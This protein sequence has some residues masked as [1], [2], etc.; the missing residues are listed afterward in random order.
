MHSWHYI[1][2]SINGVWLH[3]RQ[4]LS[5]TGTLFPYTVVYTAQ[6]TVLS[7]CTE[8]TGS[9]E[10][11]LNMFLTHCTIILSVTSCTITDYDYYKSKNAISQHTY[12]HCERQQT[13][14]VTVLRKTYHVQARSTVFRQCRLHHTN[15]C[16]TCQWHS[17]TS[18]QQSNYHNLHKTSE[19]TGVPTI[20]HYI[21]SGRLIITS[22]NNCSRTRT[23]CCYMKQITI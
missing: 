8:Q 2:A 3:C 14:G 17:A 19:Y 22:N 4:P 10:T 12:L 11:K 7:G 20:R 23:D 1:P 16:K 13:D 6:Q 18:G 21:S 5:V 15:N 9:I